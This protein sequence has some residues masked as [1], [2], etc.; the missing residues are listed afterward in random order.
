MSVTKSKKDLDKE[1][2]QNVAKNKYLAAT[3]MFF[4]VK[5]GDYHQKQE[6]NKAVDSAAQS[7]IKLFGKHEAQH[8]MLEI[9]RQ[10]LRSSR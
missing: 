6:A 9:S 10:A 3:Q 5:T 1:E 7:I 8:I 4:N 2:K